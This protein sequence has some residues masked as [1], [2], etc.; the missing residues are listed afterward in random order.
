MKLAIR[1][2]QWQ[3]GIEMLWKGILEFIIEDTEAA[4]D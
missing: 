2:F 4:R 1:N 3:S